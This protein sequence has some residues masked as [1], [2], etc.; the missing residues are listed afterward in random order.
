MTHISLEEPESV[1]RLILLT[2]FV[3]GTVY[4]FARVR[5]HAERWTLKHTMHTLLTV[6]AERLFETSELS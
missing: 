1:L 3:G 2:A 5:M 6:H 4:Y